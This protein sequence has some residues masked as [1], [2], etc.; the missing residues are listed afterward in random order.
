MV[1]CENRFS[2]ESRTHE[3][4]RPWEDGFQGTPRASQQFDGFAHL[5]QRFRV[6]RKLQPRRHHI[7]HGHECCLRRAVRI[8]L[9]VVGLEPL[10]RLAVKRPVNLDPDEILVPPHDLGRV[11]R[12]RIANFSEGNF[13][14]RCVCLGQRQGWFLGNLVPKPALRADR[15]PPG[16]PTSVPR[17]RQRLQASSGVR[18]TSPARM[19]QCRAPRSSR[20]VCSRRPCIEPGSDSARTTGCSS[21]ERL[22][23]RR[24]ESQRVRVCAR[25]CPI[26]SKPCASGNLAKNRASALPTSQK[27]PQHPRHG[28]QNLP[29]PCGAP[30]GPALSPPSLLT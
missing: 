6:S 17:T 5:A 29:G 19:A 4:A 9:E 13:R 23:A 21:C 15:T 7:V 1:S 14:R 3:L 22:R 11:A 2:V 16:R 24:S 10:V 30:A 12:T 20:G 28:S 18:V 25:S 8:G 26:G 27:L